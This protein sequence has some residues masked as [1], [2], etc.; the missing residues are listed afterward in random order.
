MANLFWSHPNGD[1]YVI[2]CVHI[3]PQHPAGD[4]VMVPCTHPWVQQHPGGDQITLPGGFKKMVPCVHWGSPHPN[5]DPHNV[6]CVH[7]MQQHPGGDT[8]IG[9]CVHHLA[10]ISVEHAGALVFYTNNT[11]L[12]NFVHD[13][14][15]FLNKLGVDILASGP[16]NIFNRANINGNPND[17]TDPFWSRYNPAIHSIQITSGI[18]TT[19]TNVTTDNIG[20]GIRMRDTLFHEMGHAIVGHAC[21]QII[22]PGDPHGMHTPTNPAEALSEGWAHFV[23]AAMLNAQ[24]NNKPIFK[25]EN[26]ETLAAGQTPNPNIEYSVGMCLWDL[27]DTN[28]DS[29]DN[30]SFSFLELLKI[31][32][33]TFPTITAGP[34]IKDVFDYCDRLIKNNPESKDIIDKVRIQNVG[35]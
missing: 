13:G 7:L 17:N 16:L 15:K 4:T 29:D 22:S 9:P 24:G 11:E 10:P 32:Q 12:Q 33:P 14:I 19:Q 5:G 6:P 34:V 26:W 3:V 28:V 8:I 35:S 1:S 27:F 31:F 21:V 25:G 2:P 23:G 20:T 30:A 18:G